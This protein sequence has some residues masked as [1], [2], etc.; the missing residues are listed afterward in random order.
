M[1]PPRQPAPLHSVLLL[2]GISLALIL[3]Q[4]GCPQGA[5]LENPEA[6]AARIGSGGTGAMGALDFT[7]IECSATLSGA[8]GVPAAD[9]LNTTCAKNF[10]HGK[11]FVVGL[12]LRPD[13]G[14]ATRTLDV[15]AMHGGIPCPDDITEECVP[16]SCPAPGTAKIINSADPTTSWILTKVHN[17][18]SDCG[19]QMPD[20]AGLNADKDACIIAIVNATAALK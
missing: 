10:C 19:G 18:Q 7:K 11:N 20:T 15:N 1:H 2:S 4:S 17:G 16:A 6:W 13:S 9:F 8:T 12:D 3:T 5:E 14:F